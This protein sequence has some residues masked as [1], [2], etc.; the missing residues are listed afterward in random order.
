MCMNA[1]MAL[2]SQV[3][4]CSLLAR[5]FRNVAL[6]SRNITHMDE[7]KTHKGAYVPYAPVPYRRPIKNDIVDLR[8]QRL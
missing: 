3:W 7:N 6:G 1:C 4:P 5:F 2:E 8:L